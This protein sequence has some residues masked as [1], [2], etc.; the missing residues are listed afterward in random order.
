MLIV[1]QDDSGDFNDIQEAL[2]YARS[3]WGDKQKTIKIKSGI[4]LV[5]S[6]IILPGNITII[7][8]GNPV[9]KMGD[10]KNLENMISNEHRNNK[11]PSSI[12]D[13]GITLKGIVVDGNRY[14]QTSTYRVC[15]WL[16]NVADVIIENSTIQNCNGEGIGT[17]WASNVRI[18]KS[19]FLNNWGNGIYFDRSSEDCIVEKSYFFGNRASNVDVYLAKRV[20]IKDNVILNS[21][22]WY[23]IDLDSVQS[24]TISNNIIGYNGRSGIMLWSGTYCKYGYPNCEVTGQSSQYNVISGNEIFNNNQFIENPKD[25]DFDGIDLSHTTNYTYFTHHNTIENNRIYCNQVLNGGV[26]K[27]QRYAIGVGWPADDYNIIRNNYYWDNYNEALGIVVFMR[28]NATNTLVE[29]NVN[30][31]P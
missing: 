19:I 10:Y 7:G 15:I 22:E 29:G 13:R 25:Y 1:A 8:E 9:L 12:V 5:N 23:G 20:L 17:L 2:N 16:L 27:T 21:T 31:P 28:G 14:K 3:L 24:S 30:H 4:Y 6:P 18:T 26:L 11:Q